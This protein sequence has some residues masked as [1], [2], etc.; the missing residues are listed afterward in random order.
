MVKTKRNYVSQVINE[1]YDNNFNHLLNEYRIKESC[2][3]MN[4]TDN[5]GNYTI[6]S[7]ALSVGFKSRSNFISTFKRFTGLTPSAYLKIAKNNG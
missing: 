3:R 1:K 5:Y 2:R 4:D 7:I 6:E